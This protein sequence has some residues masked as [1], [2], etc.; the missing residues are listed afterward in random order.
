[1]EPFEGF[2]PNVD[3]F[4][5]VQSLRSPLLDAFFTKFYLLGKGWVLL[6]AALWVWLYRRRDFPLFLLTVAIESVSVQVLKRTFD[7]PRPGSFFE[8][9]EPLEGVYRLSFPSGDAAMAFALTAF[10]WS[11]VPACVRPLLLLYALL[12]SF[13]RVYLGAH[14]P[15]DVLAGALLG[16]AS[17]GAAKVAVKVWEGIKRRKG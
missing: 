2:K 16:L 9:F 6:P 4:W 8:N 15:L 13:G 12:V 11:R 7:Q 3:L 5:W 14:F 17:Y 1:M 10:F